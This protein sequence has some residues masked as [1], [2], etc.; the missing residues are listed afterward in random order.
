MPAGDR[1]AA[2]LRPGATIVT[3]IYDCSQAPSE[4]RAG[5]QNGRVWIGSMTRTLERL[6]ALCTQP[7]EDQPEH[8]LRPVFRPRRGP[9]QGRR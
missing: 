7:V 2:D 4:E 1:I 8:G 9:P 3:E 6:A 5:M